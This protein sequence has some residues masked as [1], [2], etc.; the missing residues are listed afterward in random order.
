MQCWPKETGWRAVRSGRNSSDEGI[1]V[2]DS[3]YY[4]GEPCFRSG[5]RRHLCGPLA[6][7][8]LHITV[9]E[10]IDPAR[11]A[12][13][14]LA[15]DLYSVG[16]ERQTNKMKPSISAICEKKKIVCC[17]GLMAVAMLQRSTLHA[18]PHAAGTQQ[19]A[20]T[21]S[22][23]ADVKSLVKWVSDITPMLQSQ[24]SEADRS[25]LRAKVKSISDNL[26]TTETIN[27]AVVDNLESAHPDYGALYTQLKRLQDADASIAKSIGAIRSDLSLSGQTETDLER[28]ASDAI[29]AKGVEV[30]RMLA[31]LQYPV[32]H[33]PG[34]LQELQTK[35]KELLSLIQKAEDAVS[36][37]YRTLGGLS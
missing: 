34:E 33:T 13:A 10:H 24:G 30:N 9:G 21:T 3:A 19:P 27:R 17:V 35:S 12:G 2:Y 20:G 32:P 25:K 28:H 26:A 23:L 14:T 18:Q 22:M 29:G 37:A 16:I 7:C 8:Q 4:I 1:P 36:S 11:T 15:F 5:S 31:K 6:A